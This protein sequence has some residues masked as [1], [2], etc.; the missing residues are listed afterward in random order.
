MKKSVKE[1][2]FNI[3]ITIGAVELLKH[4]FEVKEEARNSFVNTDYYMEEIGEQ[5]SKA[6]ILEEYLALFDRA[7]SHV[8]FDEYVSVDADT[9][10]FDYTEAAEG[11]DRGNCYFRVSCKFD[12]KKY[13][14]KMVAMNVKDSAERPSTCINGW[15]QT[16]DECFQYAKKLFEDCGLETWAYIQLEGNKEVGFSVRACTDLCI[17]DYSKECIEEVVSSYYDGGTKQ[18]ERD[19]PDSSQQVILECIFEQEAC[20]KCHITK[21]VSS[22][23][24]GYAVIKEELSTGGFV[25]SLIMSNILSHE[26]AFKNSR[27]HDKEN[28]RYRRF[29]TLRCK[30][31]TFEIFGEAVEFSTFEQAYDI[32]VLLW[33]EQKFYFDDRNYNPLVEEYA[34]T[35][36]ENPK[37]YG[38]WET[39]VYENNTMTRPCWS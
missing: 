15:I 26:N 27:K 16:D 38:I 31:E 9:V 25:D 12:L 36:R 14:E 37:R 39:S 24:E 33:N 28:P 34:K 30:D 20:D 1:I 6:G 35:V 3:S 32:M 10:E 23:E 29:Y 4:I 5:M 17:A 2:S 21:N 11:N 7:D 22:K 8:I 18:V 19:Y 13:I